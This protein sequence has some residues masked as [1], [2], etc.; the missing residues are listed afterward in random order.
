MP[1]LK[2]NKAL[3]KRI[4]SSK[5]GKLLRTRAGKSHLNSAMS[6]KR[7]RQLRRKSLVAAGFVKRIKRALGSALKG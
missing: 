7:R 5:R 2:T 1:K 6:P 4:K 3:A